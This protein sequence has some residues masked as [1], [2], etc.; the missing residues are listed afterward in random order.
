MVCVTAWSRATRPRVSELKSEEAA[1]VIAAFLFSRLGRIPVR[2]YP[3]PYG[4]EG[5]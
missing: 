3:N 4:Q 1:I 5:N 2:A